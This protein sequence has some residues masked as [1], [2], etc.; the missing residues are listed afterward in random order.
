MSNQIHI[1]ILRIPKLERKVPGTLKRY[2][3][4][5]IALLSKF[6]GVFGYMFFTNALVRAPKEYQWIVA[7][8]GSPLIRE[9]NVWILTTCAYK[10][11]GKQEF[12]TVKLSAMQNMES[13]H[14]LFL[15]I[16]VG[17]VATDETVYAVVGI[18]FLLNIYTGLKIVYLLKYSSKGNAANEGKFQ[19]EKK[20][21]GSIALL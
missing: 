12:D 7:A 4:V 20:N 11:S 2:F 6:V 19:V 21:H 16:M 15:T 5:V 10:A 14:A 8:I 13:R 17:S 18:D 1:S 3:W 9:I